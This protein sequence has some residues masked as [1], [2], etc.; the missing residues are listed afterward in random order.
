MR[1]SNCRATRSS[2]LA[3]SRY[4]RC[5]SRE[6]TFHASAET[7][8]RSRG[9]VGCGSILPFTFHEACRDG[10]PANSLKNLGSA[11]A[12]GFAGTKLQPEAEENAGG[13]ERLF[14][15]VHPVRRQLQ[16]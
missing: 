14:P 11:A 8:T 4:G 7:S 3:I 10:C 6:R 15:A 16:H 12:V 1:R 13:W 2:S 5:G 9:T